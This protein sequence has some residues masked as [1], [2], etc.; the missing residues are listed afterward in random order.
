MPAATTTTCLENREVTS[1]VAEA[2][3]ATETAPP[4][5]TCFVVSLLYILYVDFI[6]KNCL[7]LLQPLSSADVRA[8]WFNNNKKKNIAKDCLNNKN[9]FTFIARFSS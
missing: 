8:H 7:K 4:I 3:G 1:R 2:A 6:K 5:P 9:L